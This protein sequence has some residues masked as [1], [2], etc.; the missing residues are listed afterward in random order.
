MNEQESLTKLLAN[1]KAGN[2]YDSD[3]LTNYDNIG[4][5]FDFQE[6]YKHALVIHAWRGS[7]DAAKELHEAV[8]PEWRVTHAFGLISGEMATF[9]LTHNEKISTYVSGKSVN[10]ARAWLIAIIEALIATSLQGVTNV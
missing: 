3:Q 6:H 8:V 4:V 10:P 7:L 9:N 2:S 1:L 5:G